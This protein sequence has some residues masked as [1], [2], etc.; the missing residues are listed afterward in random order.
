MAPPV[1]RKLR[2]SDAAVKKLP[3]GRSWDTEIGGFGIKV[4]PTGKLQFVL[5]YRSREKKQREF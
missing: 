4:Y 5:R 2:L 1:K 3:P